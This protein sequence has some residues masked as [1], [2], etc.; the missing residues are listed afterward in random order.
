MAFTVG[1]NISANLARSYN[2]AFNAATRAAK[3]ASERIG[4]A[5]QK[6]GAAFNQRGGLG[7]VLAGAAFTGAITKTIRTAVTLENSML[8]LRKAAGGIKESDFGGLTK[9]LNKLAVSG[10]VGSSI[11]DLYASATGFAQLGYDENINS[12]LSWTKLADNTAIA[13]DESA[14]SVATSLGK[15]VEAFASNQSLDEK[16]ILASRLA[17]AYN[18]LSNNQASVAR[19]LLFFNQQAAGIAKGLNLSGEESAA[20]GSAL[21]AL[22]TQSG[23]AAQT[24][25]SMVGPM[26]NLDGQ[27]TK[28]QKT[29]Q[30]L[31]FTASG[32]K[33]AFQEDGQT[34]IL[35]VLEA[36]EK[37]DKQER[38]TAALTIFGEHYGDD[39]A[40]LAGSMDTY[41]KNIGLVADETV[42]LGSVSQEARTRLGGMGTKMVI[43][44]NQLK[45]IMANF[46]TALF[47]TIEK[48]LLALTK[49]SE[50]AIPFAE[51][52][53][54]I[55]EAIT[56]GAT[57]II[58]TAI[59]KPVL[60][61]II[62]VI[63]K[64]GPLGGGILILT[65]AIF[66]LT[67]ALDNWLGSWVKGASEPQPFPAQVGRAVALSEWGMFWGNFF[68]DGEQLDKNRK[69]SMNAFREGLK[70]PGPPEGFWDPLK[71]GLGNFWEG[72]KSGLSPAEAEAGQGWHP[73]ELARRAANA[74]AADTVTTLFRGSRFDSP[75]ANPLNFSGRRGG[76]RA[77]T[78]RHGLAALFAG[79][80]PDKVRADL[81]EQRPGVHFDPNNPLGTTW[82]VG[83]K[84]RRIASAAERSLK[85]GSREFPGASQKPVSYSMP[86][87]RPVDTIDALTPRAVEPVAIPPAVRGP[88]PLITVA[89]RK[90]EDEAEAQAN[91]W[92]RGLGDDNRA[93]KPVMLK[94]LVVEG[95]GTGINNP[96]QGR[97]TEDTE[98]PER[99]G[100][101]AWDFRSTF[102]RLWPGQQDE[103]E[104]DTDDLIEEEVEEQPDALKRALDKL[105]PDPASEPQT[106]REIFDDYGTMSSLRP[107]TPAAEQARL[108][109]ESNELQRQM[110]D[111]MARMVEHNRQWEGRQGERMTRRAQRGQALYDLPQGNLSL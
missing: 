36:L 47:P 87:R 77:A 67:A 72:V 96:W 22:G 68:R 63:A 15:T 31:G 6:A 5:G 78:D 10:E 73:E 80:D 98:S 9:G 74:A 3:N 20:F 69:Q 70:N 59:A 79:Y 64:L 1:I 91:A 102:E 34:A 45:L 25:K 106:P 71:R 99:P 29:M 32:L 76:S 109:Q 84:A 38:A 7:N 35:S 14:G 86:T 46:G 111:L 104:I 40:K 28:V 18:H 97:W 27:S 92:Y 51:N 49:V 8:D 44:G 61:P 11:E 88:S 43:A 41:R 30:G 23:V 39:I 93:D 54:A 85:P 94:E 42:F 108:L 82:W 48:G 56:V 62:G 50:F 107:G 75:A 60:G 26:V 83:D 55:T 33:Q 57:A 52:N 105:A 13:F 19:E 110:L 21:I 37:L 100:S 58:G 53:P 2:R 24:L 101:S 17:D 81:L 89:R 103:G 4:R 65:G 66:G 16:Y 12:L 90:L 95:T